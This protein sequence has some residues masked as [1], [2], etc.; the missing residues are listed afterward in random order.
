M[1]P[2]TA[3]Y[4]CSSLGQTKL[5]TSHLRQLSQ[6]LVHLQRLPGGY[7]GLEGR[8]TREAPAVHMWTK[9]H[10]GQFINRLMHSIK[11]AVDIKNL[12]FK[13]VNDTH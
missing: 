4:H 7:P 6:R 9:R 8:E 1:I 3:Q 5:L 10:T 12:C 11:I 13:S 2:S